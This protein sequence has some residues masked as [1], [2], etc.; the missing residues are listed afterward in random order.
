MSEHNTGRSLTEE[1]RRKISEGN[2]GVQR[3][4]SRQKLTEDQVIK[5]RKMYS[6]GKYTFVALAKLF[7]VTPVCIRKIV[8]HETWPDVLAA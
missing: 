6:T 2:K 8:R 5:I 7:A 1:H 3:T 4:P